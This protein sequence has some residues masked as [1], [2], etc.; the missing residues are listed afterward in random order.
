VAERVDTVVI[1]AGQAGLSASYHLTARGR[2]HVVLE[3]G[4][5]GDTWRTKRWDGFY[6]NTPNWAQRLPG[7]E[8]AGAE[9][10]AFSSR[11]EV[12]AYLDDY[13]ASFAAPVRTQT[14]VTA[15]EPAD[16][17]Y[18]VRTGDGEWRAA[19]VI[20]AAGAY[21]RPTPP[22]L[23]GGA[24][25][26]VLQLHTSEYR[27]PEQLAD[28]AILIVGGGQSGCQIAD[29]LIAAGRRT[30]MSV[31]RCGWFPRRYR[32]VEVVRWLV[33]LGMM[34]DTVDSL[35]SPAARLACNPPVSGND[36]GHDCHPRWLARRGTELVGRLV[37]FD[38]GRARLAQGLEESLAWG[39]EFAAAFER[40]VDEHVL[41]TGIAVE[42]PE[43]EPV[44]VPVVVR[45]ELDLRAEG[46]GTILWANGYR[47]DLSWIDLPLAD[48]Q[49]WPAQ[50]RGATAFP[51]LW[52]VG[53]HWLHRRS[54][55]LFLG[56]G[57]DAEH[58]VAQLG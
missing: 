3:R 29:E 22:Q 8:Y 57:A 56:V 4:E 25:A 28:G 39:D 12:V 15:V 54:S 40:R 53:V 52:F 1:G 10:D 19:N 18:R 16:G 17:G 13:A 51:G 36:G 11:A 35:P 27:S 34:D 2:D 26:D 37:G 14:P 33:D 58:V 55:A 9:P 32:G 7:H 41:A 48:E 23:A 21:Q 46:I 49:G 31:G 6:L 20:V 42:E 30:Y 44:D 5:I 38:G 43:P 45:D 47:P 24:P 50:R